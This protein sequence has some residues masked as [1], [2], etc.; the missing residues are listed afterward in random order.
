[1]N[2]VKLQQT[3]VHLTSNQI[4]NSLQ[5]EKMDPLSHAN[6]CVQS[7]KCIAKIKH[8]FLFLAFLFSAVEQYCVTQSIPLLC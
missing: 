7:L 6:P 3:K 1:M 5:H 2:C 8:F 4:K